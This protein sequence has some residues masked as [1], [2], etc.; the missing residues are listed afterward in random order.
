MEYHRFV[1][2]DPEVRGD[3]Q[4]QRSGRNETEEQREEA[5][6]PDA[7]V[8]SGRGTDDEAGRWGSRGAEGRGAVARWTRRRVVCLATCAVIV[9]SP[10]LRWITRRQLYNVGLPNKNPLL[11]LREPI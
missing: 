2:V 8:Q 1:R 11:S 4:T 5:Q 6:G 9:R 10:V 7:A 3:G